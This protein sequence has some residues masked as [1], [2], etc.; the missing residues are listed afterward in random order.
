MIRTDKRVR[1][2]WTMIAALLTF[3][4]GNSLLDGKQSAK[5]SNGIVAMDSHV[6]DKGIDEV[7]TLR[8]LVRK[9]AHLVEFACLGMLLAWGCR[10]AGVDGVS[11]Y[12][13][14]LF[15]GLTAA[16]ILDGHGKQLPVVERM[17]EGDGFPG[18]IG[19]I[20]GEDLLAVRRAEGSQSVCHGEDIGQLEFPALM[21]E[22]G[23]RHGTVLR[24]KKGA[25]AFT[26]APEFRV[27]E[28][29]SPRE[30]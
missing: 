11:F 16:C 7:K 28:D 15:G 3:I 23:I 24:P 6:Q 1:L 27:F 22:V 20:W 8:K 30:A 4:W 14:P 19:V 9:S 10:L 13:L 18:V 12:T 21:E 29:Y 5:L 2:C 26:T 25:A 17:G